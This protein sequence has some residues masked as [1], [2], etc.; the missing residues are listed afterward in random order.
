MVIGI[1]VQLVQIFICTLNFTFIIKGLFRKHYWGVDAFR[2]SVVKSGNLRISR[3]WATPATSLST[4]NRMPTRGQQQNRQSC[5]LPV[6]SCHCTTI[7]TSGCTI[8]IS[9]QHLYQ[10]IVQFDKTIVLPRNLATGRIH[11]YLFCNCPLEAILFEVLRIHVWG[12]QLGRNNT[13]RSL[14]TIHTFFK[15][16]MAHS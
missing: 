6:D 7:V 16:G 15:E 5:L 14:T 9:E 11:D 1:Y 10:T 13:G 8:V 3:I 2:F 12:S 4:S